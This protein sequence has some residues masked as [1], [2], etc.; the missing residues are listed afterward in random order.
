ML[1][2]RQTEDQ[3]HR[4]TGGLE[5]CRFGSLSA[6]LVHRHTGGLEISNMQSS[7]KT[8]VHRRTGG[9]EMNEHH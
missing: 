7:R 1:V 6:K 2:Y 3:V 8:L 4:H 9:L 5:I